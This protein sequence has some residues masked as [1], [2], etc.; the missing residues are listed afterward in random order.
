[1]PRGKAEF[2]TMDSFDTSPNM[3]VS[4]IVNANNMNVP[5]VRDMNPNGS[6]TPPLENLA[7]SIE[8]KELS[9]DIECKFMSSSSDIH[10][11]LF[12]PTQIGSENIETKMARQA[13]EAIWKLGKKL[14]KPASKTKKLSPVAPPISRGRSFNIAEQ[15]A[16]DPKRRALAVAKRVGGIDKGF[17]DLVVKELDDGIEVK[18]TLGRYAAGIGGGALIGGYIGHKRGT[19]KQNY[20]QGK[21]LAK[22][23]LSEYEKKKKNKLH[24]VKVKSIAKY[25]GPAAAG[26]ATAAVTHGVGKSRGKAQAKENYEKNKEMAHRNY[27]KMARIHRRGE[28]SI[29][30]D[31]GRTYYSN[32]P[33]ENELEEM[34]R[35]AYGK[36][37]EDIQVKELSDDIE[38]KNMGNLN[39]N[40]TMQ[41]RNTVRPPA[42]AKMG[43]PS[44]PNMA[45]IGQMKQGNPMGA[46]GV[47]P[48][49]RPSNAP[50]AKNIFNGEEITA[51]GLVKW[52]KGGAHEAKRLAQTGKRPGQNTLQRVSKKKSPKG[53][54]KIPYDESKLAEK[55]EARQKY[56]RRLMANP[57]ATGKLSYANRN[58]AL[59]GNLPGFKLRGY[60]NEIHSKTMAINIAKNVALPAGVGLVSSILGGDVANRIQDRRNKQKPV[61]RIKNRQSRK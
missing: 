14:V 19:K 33:K 31:R 17:G 48:P 13:G 10:G 3:R 45:K 61:G 15:T 9:D 27:R 11:G 21:E 41:R 40:A 12:V 55:N 20:E 32:P 7:E 43:K 26:L 56:Y 49:E 36:G 8:V 35:Y 6:I 58:E 53:K 37:Y 2:S 46:R 30:L 28:T 44:K 25:V 5:Q 47:T 22:T 16:K 23:Y 24:A 60:S 57:D 4:P 59:L 54:Y 51:K 42:M 34:R 18:G 1:M 38:T 50:I 39:F 52:L 29:M